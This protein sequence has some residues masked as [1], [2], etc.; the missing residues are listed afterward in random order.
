[1]IDQ[2]VRTTQG[3]LTYICEKDNGNLRHRMDHL[4]CFVAGMLMMGAKELPAAEVD[5]R[6]ETTAA[7]LSHTC[8]E[9]YVRTKTVLSPEYVVFHPERGHGQDMSIPNDA[10][11][12][13]LRPEAAEAMYY[14]HYYTG[15]PKY[16]EWANDMMQAF[17]RHSK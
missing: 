10:P 15:D 14:M 3:G 5:P 6:W 9:M 7:A 4:A 1:M 8:H 2:L 17:D 11:H 13:L 12:N 16:R